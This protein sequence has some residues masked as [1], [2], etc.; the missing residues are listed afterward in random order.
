MTI[1]VVD[2]DRSEQADLAN[3]LSRKYRSASV[4][5]FRDPLL[6]VKFGAN[7]NVDALYTVSRMKRLSG[8]E[9]GRLMRQLYP[10]IALTLIADDDSGRNEAMRSMA[11]GYVTRPVTEEALL[12]AENEEW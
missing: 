10:E 11:D 7:N 5:C 3:I 4:Q 8:L 6:A 2:P 9:L 1:V 12:L